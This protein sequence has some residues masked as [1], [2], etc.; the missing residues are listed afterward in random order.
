[1]TRTK[2]FNEDEALNEAMM[3]FWANGF[4]ATSMQ[5]LEN[6]MGL[7]R[8]SIYNAFGN[9]RE[10]FTHALKRYF[11]VILSGFV[12]ALSEAKTARE[13]VETVLRETISL[14]FNESMPGGCMMILSVMENEQHD[15]ET[16]RLLDGALT[17]LTAGIEERLTLG[18]L[19]GEKNFKKDNAV[20]ANQITALITGVV[21]MARANYPRKVLEAMATSTIEAL[22]EQ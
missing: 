12:T 11:T 10:L 16:Q 4:A 9:K 3:L 15:A 2:A 20:V 17:Q 8:T 21:V 13:G 18:Q 7:K 1:M 6:S 19:R 5:M 14:N 22:F